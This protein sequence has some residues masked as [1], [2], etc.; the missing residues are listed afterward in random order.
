MAHKYMDI[1]IV[2]FLEEKMK[3]NTKHYQSDF[4]YDKK[5][6]ENAADSERKEDKTLLW[7]SRPCG[8]QCVKEQEAFIA[9]SSANITWR[10]YAEQTADPIIAFTVEITGR[11]KG[12]IRGNVYELDFRAHAAE[13]AKSP[14]NPQNVTMT[15][16]DGYVEADFPFPRNY[17]SVK[18]LTAAHGAIKDSFLTPDQPERLQH[19]LSEQK[20]KRDSLKR[21]EYKPEKKTS[22]Q[23]AISSAEER[24]NKLNQK[25]K[26]KQSEVVR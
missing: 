22:L 8:T 16:E 15:F 25:T 1:D 3:S 24:R 17:F 21:K 9:G 13:V 26:E 20:A 12:V 19:I 10:F 6:F 18:E 11:D 7:L 14:V 23:T 4:E 5:G 2:A